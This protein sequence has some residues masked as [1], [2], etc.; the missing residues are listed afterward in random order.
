MSRNRNENYYGSNTARRRARKLT[1]QK[2]K[3]GVWLVTGGE[4]GHGV[5]MNGG[6]PPVYEC[7]CN[8]QKG[9]KDEMC[10]HCLAVWAQINGNQD[11]LKAVNT[12]PGGQR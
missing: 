4:M 3:P 1:A 10:S 9:A 5:T 6:D 7:D 2:I 11:F 8:G 12:E